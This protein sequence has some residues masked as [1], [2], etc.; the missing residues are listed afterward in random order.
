[1][2]DSRHV[3]PFGVLAEQHGSAGIVLARWTVIFTLQ[4]PSITDVSPW[5]EHLRHEIA[6]VSGKLIVIGPNVSDAFRRRLQLLEYRW[7]DRVQLHHQR[8]INFI[9]DAGKA[10]FGLATSADVARI[11]HHQ[12]EA[13]AGMKVLYHNQQG[14][15]SVLNLT[16]LQTVRNHEDIQHLHEAYKGLVGDHAV[17]FTRLYALEVVNALMSLFDQVDLMIDIVS[18]QWRRYHLMHEALRNGHLSLL[19]FSDTVFSEV[20]A[21]FPDTGT[22]MPIDWYRT[23]ANVR[24]V[25]VTASETVAV[26]DLWIRR[27]ELYT[28]WTLR[29]YW[30]AMDNMFTRLTVQPERLVDDTH[31]NYMVPD[32]CMGSSPAMCAVSRETDPCEQALFNGDAPGCPREWVKTISTVVERLK[33]NVYI[34]QPNVT[35][36]LGVQCESDYPTTM[37]FVAPTLLELT[38]VCLVTWPGGRSLPVIHKAAHYNMTRFLPPKWSPFVITPALLIQLQRGL[39]IHDK[40]IVDPDN[41]VNLEPLPPFTPYVGGGLP[42]YVWILFVLIIVALMFGLV[43]VVKKRHETIRR[44]ARIIQPR[45]EPKCEEA[46]VSSQGSVGVV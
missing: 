46:P 45:P 18:D 36:S 5:L 7:S 13:E 14:L 28:R 26:C 24:A 9:G 17:L 44:V 30:T 40:L 20:L 15:V 29:S 8:L 4:P 16:R 43:V 39:Q 21:N 2:A 10:L 23:Y 32:A 38:R 41:V 33:D 27:P 31:A 34:I 35:L 25:S 6:Q 19:V 3:L 12:R 42:W 37:T 1:M 11:R 22:K